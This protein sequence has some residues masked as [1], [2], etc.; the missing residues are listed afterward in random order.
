VRYLIQR[1]CKTDILMVATI[2]DAAL[3]RSPPTPT[4]KA[5]VR[6]SDEYFP[7]INEKSVGTIHQ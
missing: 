6:V 2:A 3:V 7:L 5:Y 4:A 1:G